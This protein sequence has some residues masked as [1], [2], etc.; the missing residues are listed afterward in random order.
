MGMKSFSIESFMTEQLGLSGNELVLFAILWK[1]SKA[2]KE[3]VQGNYSFLSGRM[4]VT[5]P[6]MYNAVKRLIERGFVEQPEKGVYAVS[7]NLS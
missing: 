4:G 2:G 7:V 1:E 5:I 3:K 6:T